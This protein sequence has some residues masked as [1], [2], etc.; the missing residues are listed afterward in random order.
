MQNQLFDGVGGAEVAVVL[1]EVDEL[2]LPSELA[3]GAELSEDFDASPPDL[4]S[5]PLFA[6]AGFAEE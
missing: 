6:D 2:E 4:P 5:E 3:A 1:E